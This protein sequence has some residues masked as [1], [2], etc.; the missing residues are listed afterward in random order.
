M[1]KIIV[2]MVILIFNLCSG[3]GIETIS[4]LPSPTTEIIETT[5]NMGS[6]TPSDLNTFN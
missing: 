1:K 6:S 2:L 3:C 4:E 5:P